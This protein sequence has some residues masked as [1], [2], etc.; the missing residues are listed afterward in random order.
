MQTKKDVTHKPFCNVCCSDQFQPDEQF[1]QFGR[2]GVNHQVGQCLFRGGHIVQHPFDSHI[3]RRLA[4][5]FQKGA[6]FL[7]RQAAGLFS[8]QAA[9]EV[10][11]HLK[12]MILET[13]LGIRRKSGRK[14][15]I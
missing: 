15:Q 8:D 10:I 2:H 7:I 9:V 14:E 6:D 3:Y 12:I 5:H 4:V 13:V 1:P 11:D